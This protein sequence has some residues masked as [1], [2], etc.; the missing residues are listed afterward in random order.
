MRSLL[1]VLCLATSLPAD[2]PGEPLASPGKLLYSDDFERTEIGPGWRSPNGF[3]IANGVLQGRQKHVTHGAVARM[4]VDFQDAVIRLKFR[5]NGAKY[6]SFV[7]DDKQCETTHSGHL[8][9]IHVTPTSLRLGDDKEGAMRNDILALR[10]SDDPH[11]KM[12]AEKLLVGRSVTAPIELR[13]EQ[14]YALQVEIVGDEMRAAIDDKPLARLKSP[15][16]AHPTKRE[17]GPTVG[18]ATAE[19]D[20]VQFYAPSPTAA[21]TTTRTKAG[22]N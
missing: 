2:D 1:L 16:I 20:D 8:L 14:W 5:L 22:G 3:Q 11:K 21:G 9:R 4:Q 19:F 7:A 6:I 18:G 15:G 10:T 13:P 12:E 17:F